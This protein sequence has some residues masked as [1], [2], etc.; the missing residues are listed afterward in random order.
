MKRS[1]WHVLQFALAF[2]TAALVNTAASI[3]GF[4]EGA[5][6]VITLIVIFAVSFGMRSIFPKPPKP[7]APPPK[8]W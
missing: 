4:S 6:F 1:T 7:P 2:G 5:S 3:S 8:P